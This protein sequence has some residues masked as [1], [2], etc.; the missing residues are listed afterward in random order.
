VIIQD[1]ADR[2]EGT[3]GPGFDKEREIVGTF[4]RYDSGS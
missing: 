1:P 4:I 3:P 2:A